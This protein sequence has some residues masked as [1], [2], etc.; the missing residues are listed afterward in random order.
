MAECVFTKQ[1]P[2]TTGNGTVR[3]AVPENPALETN[4]KSIGRRVV[5]KWPFEVFKM[6]AVR[7]L[8]FD[9]TEY[10]AVRSAV[11]ENPTP[12]LN[13]KGIC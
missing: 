4:T 7:H 9:P 2:D 13:V 11:L 12:E 10:G 3:S 6:A 5:Q 8:G 1:R